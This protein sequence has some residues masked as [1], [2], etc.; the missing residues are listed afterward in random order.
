[1][2]GDGLAGPGGADFLCSV[3]AQGE[4][5]IHFGRAGI[6]EFGPTFA[7]KS[8]GGQM[9]TFEL[10]QS[11][12]MYKSARVATCAMRGEGR[13]SFLAEDRFGHDG[14]G[15]IPGTEK[16]HVIL[17]RHCA[18]NPLIQHMRLSACEQVRLKRH[19]CQDTYIVYWRR[20]KETEKDGDGPI[21]GHAFPGAGGRDAAAAFEPDRGAGDLRLLFCGNSADQPAENFAA[22]RVPA[23]YG[24]HRGEARG[25]VDALP[26]GD[27]GGSG[28]RQHLA[29]NAE[30]FEAEAGNAQ[31][32]FAA[33]LRVLRTAEIRTSARRS[34]TDPTEP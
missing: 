21:H 4:D 24:N 34:T 14:A 32:Q 11:S 17:R 19:I 8:L 13:P 1:M 30:T 31:G 5:E 12:G 22:S 6:C 16:E 3:V 18:A 27:A 10:A 15:R 33:Q 28:R 9:G 25:E 2:R 20:G 29:R 26:A 23:T 7:A